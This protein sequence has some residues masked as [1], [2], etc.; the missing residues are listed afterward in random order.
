MAFPFYSSESERSSLRFSAFLSQHSADETRHTDEDS[1]DSLRR[2]NRENYLGLRRYEED[3]FSETTMIDKNSLV[4]IIQKLSNSEE[5]MRESLKQLCSIVSTMCPKP[6][7]NSTIKLML[8]LNLL[9]PLQQFL[10]PTTHTDLIILSLQLIHNIL[11]C[12]ILKFTKEILYS[13]C[14]SFFPALF[15]SSVPKIIELTCKCVHFLSIFSTDFRD[16]CVQFDLVAPVISIIQ[17]SSQELFFPSASQSLIPQSSS[18]LCAGLMAFEGLSSVRWRGRGSQSA[19]A[20]AATA[21]DNPSPNEEEIDLSSSQPSLSGMMEIEPEASSSSAPQPSTSS[22]EPSTSNVNETSEEPHAEA[23]SAAIKADKLL[24][25]S[26]PM[27][28][29]LTSSSDENIVVHSTAAV[30]KLT[31]DNSDAIK[32]FLEWENIN[33]FATLLGSENPLIQWNTLRTLGNCLQYSETNLDAIWRLNIVHF[34]SH[35]ILQPNP[36]LRKEALW[37][38]VTIIQCERK[39]IA[40][41]FNNSVISSM[42][43]V[44]PSSQNE[45]QKEILLAIESIVKTSTLCFVRLVELNLVE[46]LVRL[47]PNSPNPIIY[48]ILKIFNMLLSSGQFYKEF[49]V[50]E[51]KCNFRFVLDTAAQLGFLHFPAEIQDSD[52]S[53]DQLNQLLAVITSFIHSLQPS[54]SPSIRSANIVVLRICALRGDAYLGILVNHENNKIRTIAEGIMENW[55]NNQESFDEMN[56]RNLP[57][58]VNFSFLIEKKLS[59]E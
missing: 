4:Q 24:N 37:I 19:V 54:P 8:S 35:L 16:Y 23:G 44:L 56:E 39:Y 47:L 9:E 11:A 57:I 50:Q 51:F 15:Q 59:E 26:M 43:S 7:L 53:N 32:T 21:S 2:K 10:K 14:L 49:I 22:S 42:L 55:F 29:C 5:E 12:E 48:F 46:A 25:D 31:Y 41:L 3:S 33:S 34:L 38:S 17:T 40:S 6:I 28:L 58:T 20:T 36:R 18:V 30:Y 27:I 13:S 1:A 52:N 45:S